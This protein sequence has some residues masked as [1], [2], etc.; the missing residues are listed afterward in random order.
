MNGYRKTLLESL[1]FSSIL[2]IITIG[3]SFPVLFFVEAASIFGLVSNLLLLEFAS[4]LIVG[5]CLMARQPLEDDK[6]FD[7]S[8]EPVAAWR[9]ALR[10]RLLL[11]MS[12]FVLLYAI[13]F[14]LISS[15]ILP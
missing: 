15:M 4:L 10:G 9:W 5:G 6:R 1:A 8:G 13:L 7:S 2:A 3:I 12:I 14:G 11:I